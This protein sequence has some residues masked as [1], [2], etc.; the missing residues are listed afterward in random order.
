MNIAWLFDVDGVL[1]S[2]TEKR[3]TQPEIFNQ[4]IKRLEN[5]DLVGLNT[6]RAIDFIITQ[7][8]DPLE[9]Q[10]SNRSLLKNIYAIG[11]KGATWITFNEKGVKKIDI[12]PKI[13]VPVE[14]QNQTR[15]LVS[16]PPYSEVMF[17]DETKKTIITIEINMGTSPNDFKELQSELVQPFQDLLNQNHL[18]E[19]FEIVLSRIAIDFQSKHVGKDLG[20]RKFVE[21]L[22]KDGNIPDKYICFADDTSDYE[23]LTELKRLG[24]DAKLVFVGEKEKLEGLDLTPVIFTSQPLDKGTLEYLQNN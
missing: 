7:I 15:K 14:I 20:A 10:I 6:G 24:K 13:S 18:D 21:L 4:L 5:G 11:E 19:D 22:T 3:V 23:M 17:Y 2:S 8:L 16:Q 1:T 9:K 12:D